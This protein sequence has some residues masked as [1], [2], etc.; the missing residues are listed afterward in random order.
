MALFPFIGV[1]AAALPVHPITPRRAGTHRGAHPRSRSRAHSFTHYSL[2]KRLDSM[3]TSAASREKVARQK[4][5]VKAHMPNVY[6]AIKDKADDIGR[7]A[8][9][10]VDRGMSGEPNCF[11]AFENRCVVGTPFALPTIMADVAVS[12]VRF[13]VAH[14]VVWANIEKEP[15]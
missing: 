8:W 7:D 13:G 1:E 15:S 11:Y 4:E 12:M 14:V 2:K 3:D 9:L 10:L 6:Q 5:L